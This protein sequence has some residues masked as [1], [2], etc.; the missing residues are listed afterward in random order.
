MNK[1]D[2]ALRFAHYNEL[3]DKVNWLAR[4]RAM[5]SVTPIEEVADRYALYEHVQRM[6]GPGAITYLEFGVH[7]GKSL[8]AWLASNRAAASRFVG[9]DTFTGLPEHWN[10]TFRQG[11]FSTGGNPPAIDDPRVE[12]EIGLFQNTLR[13]FL[14]TFEPRGHLVV[15]LDADLYSATLYALTQLD[16][17]MPAGTILVFDEFQSYLHEFR[18]WYDYISAYCRAWRPLA[19]AHRGVHIAIELTS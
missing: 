17:H 3:L 10:Q 11:A 16:A 6:L 8:R 13:P 19:W 7:T 15:H 4:W 2:I 18:A 9:F 14:K 12:F 5:M 1:R